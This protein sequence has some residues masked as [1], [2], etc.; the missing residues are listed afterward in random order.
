MLWDERP[1]DGPSH[2]ETTSLP[3]QILANGS[4]FLLHAGVPDS[5]VPELVY[6]SNVP[7]FEKFYGKKVWVGVSVVLPSC[8]ACCL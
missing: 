8:I 2:P 5:K 1:W 6:K 7:R 4:A 3:E